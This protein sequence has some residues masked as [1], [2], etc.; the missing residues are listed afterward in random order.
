MSKAN[1]APNSIIVAVDD[2]FFASKIRG[3]AEALGRQITMVRTVEGL[4]EQ[5]ELL[6]PSLII[7]DLNSTRIDPIAAIQSLKSRPELKGL[8]I[9]GFLSHV[10]VDLKHSAEQAGCDQVMPRSAFTQRLPEILGG[11]RTQG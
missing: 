5:A 7:L 4:I 2:M 3:T 9:L 10:Q 8:P 11:E 1:E 6:S